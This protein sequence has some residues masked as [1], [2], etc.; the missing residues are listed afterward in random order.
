[1]TYQPKVC[2]V[3][4]D[5]EP[6]VA[7]LGSQTCFTVPQQ[8]ATTYLLK[9][10]DLPLKPGKRYA[11]QVQ[12]TDL[13]GALEFQNTGNSEV[14]WFRYGK[15]CTAPEDL[16]AEEIG[17]NRVNLSWQADPQAIGY[18]VYYKNES[19]AGWQTQTTFGTSISLNGLD[20]K[21]PYSFKISTLCDIDNESPTSPEETWEAEEI[22]TELQKLIDAV[23]HPLDQ[24]SSSTTPTASLKTDNVNTSGQ[25]TSQATTEPLPTNIADLLP[26]DPTKIPCVSQVRGFENCSVTHDGVT[27]MGTEPLQSLDVGDPLTIYDMLAIVTEISIREP[28]SG[29]A[30]V[31]LPMLNDMMMAVE[32][33]NVEIK[34]SKPVAKGGCVT[35]VPSNGYFRA[36]TGLSRE[37]LKAEEVALIDQIRRA[38]DPGS[39]YTT[40]GQQI[41]QYDQTT[42]EIADA[43]ATGQSLSTEQKEALLAQTIS[44]NSQI[45]T[46]LENATDLIGGSTSGDAILA[47]IQAILDQLA[48]NQTA[49]EAGTS[50]PSV[51]NIGSTITGITD[52]IRT[53]LDTPP[54]DTPRIQNLQATKITEKSATLTWEG[55]K[56][57]T[58]YIVSVQKPGEGERIFEV[59]NTK[60]TV[61]NLTK[62]SNY[63]VK[64]IGYEGNQIVDEYQNGYFTTL[65]S[66]L[67][68]PENLKIIHLGEGKANVTWDKNAL[69]LKYKLK[70][71]DKAG[72]IKYAYPTNNELELAGLASDDNFHLELVAFSKTDEI[73][74]PAVTDFESPN[75]CNR[76]KY[77]EVS[78]NNILEG[79]SVTITAPN[80]DSEVSWY[81]NNTLIFIAGQSHTF[82]PSE[83]TNYKARCTIDDPNYTIR[84]ASCEAIT[85]ILV[86]P[87]CDDIVAS[88]TPNN[89]TFG[90][91]ALLKVNG[92]KS[93]I[94]W[95]NDLEKPLFSQNSR[96]INPDQIG[97]TNY[98]VSCKNTENKT[99]WTKL[100]FNVGIHCDLKYSIQSTG[101]KSER[102]ST[103]VLSGC[104]TTPSFDYSGGGKAKLT[105]QG[106][107]NSGHWIKF[108]NINQDLTLNVKCGSIC[109]T[110]INVPGLPW[111][112]SQDCDDFI[113][114]KISDNPLVIGIKNLGPIPL[115][116]SWSDIP[117]N[118]EN[119]NEKYKYLTSREIP[120]PLKE[121]TKYAVTSLGG[122]MAEIVL[123]PTPLTDQSLIEC[124]EFKIIPE[125]NPV[126]PDIVVDDPFL[127]VSDKLGGFGGI[128]GIP[129]WFFDKMVG[130]VLTPNGSLTET[131]YLFTNTLTA[132][133]CNGT[134]SW[135]FE[136]QKIGG[137]FNEINKTLDINETGTY[138]ATCSETGKTTTVNV[139]RDV[140]IKT[141]DNTNQIQAPWNTFPGNNDP[142]NQE[143]NTATP[144]PQG[145][146]CS[147]LSVSTDQFVEYG[148]S[149]E[150]FATCP[151][152]KIY[153]QRL[154]PIIA[155]DANNIIQNGNSIVVNN[156]RNFSQYAATCEINN[157][158][159]CVKR[160]NIFVNC[161]L[162]V[163]L[164]NG[165]V[166][167][168]GCPGAGPLFYYKYYGG[169]WDLT[170]DDPSTLK[171]V[172]CR[173]ANYHLV[174]MVDNL[175]LSTPSG[176][177]NGQT[178]LTA[179][180]TAETTD[181]LQPTAKKAAQVFEKLLCDDLFGVYAQPQADGTKK[182]SPDQAR[183]ILESFKNVEKSEEFNTLGFYLPEL[184]DQMA[185]D[186]ANGNCPAL[187]TALTQNMTGDI[188]LSSTEI[189]DALTKVLE[190]AEGGII[191]GASDLLAG[192]TPPPV[193]MDNSACFDGPNPPD[194][195]AAAIQTWYS[196]DVLQ[197]NW[198]YLYKD[199]GNFITIKENGKYYHIARQV[200]DG[201]G[202]EKFIFV[203]AGK[204]DYQEFKPVGYACPKDVYANYGNQL[205]KFGNLMEFTI[206]QGGIIMCSA[207]MGAAGSAF[208]GA[209]IELM[210]EYANSQ[211][212]ISSVDWVNVGTNLV[213]TVGKF[214]KPAKEVLKLLVDA[215]L[216]Y[217]NKDG[218]Q[219]ILVE[220]DGVKQ[221][222]LIKAT[223]EVIVGKISSTIRSKYEY[224]TFERWVRDPQAKVI[225]ENFVSKLHEFSASFIENYF[226]EKLN[227]K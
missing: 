56:R 98:T 126:L 202:D 108:T 205:N 142:L 88:V 116:Q 34:A 216:D 60:L 199:W 8:T 180:A 178:D 73:S 129:L 37:D 27:L 36:R 42:K 18:K 121:T 15:A 203:E 227:S 223:S 64:I 143:T 190:Q 83:T 198:E 68:K 25:P 140:P 6:N 189:T 225:Y 164:V 139:I 149:A 161:N 160:V 144:M 72:L 2:E 124:P 148:K 155:G 96:I 224:Y 125:K 110:T 193:V 13:N 67:P 113:L 187:V 16:K 213:P 194:A 9:A 32:F 145:G 19:A 179:N 50:F 85:E 107:I 212:D 81:V 153:W 52:Q 118:Y 134:V 200:T 132:V 176:R 128:I 62:S 59:E 103:I 14:A 47:Q 115:I 33:S 70:Y 147:K 197:K 7:I 206:V 211:G 17:P 55:D 3:A 210:K 86:K 158:P 137:Y 46:W 66:N 93:D 24:I 28:Y 112:R 170:K 105:G 35:N 53:L 191:D 152:G 135:T 92:C 45:S 12:A 48:S 29:K 218:W 133:N 69:H 99:C 39:T 209:A 174:C 117:G 169:N 95:Y 177:V 22:D 163:K 123:P 89:P 30:L 4:E 127:T 188:D 84:R 201:W 20:Q 1:V 38:Q 94:V 23:L 71:T 101:Q 82:T 166:T 26:T 41:S 61:E 168:T 157:K 102:S 21:E 208:Y 5:D 51:P 109:Q 65:N 167:V 43:T 100:N 222:S 192:L 141:W 217:T 195:P 220:L 90:N 49:I 159:V 58:K 185:T 215:A 181:C 78:A 57:F 63:N 150:L 136:G 151:S 76:F 114:A 207:G 165:K 214:G 156:I 106:Q 104:P 40:F 74:D 97:E 79:E 172:E 183:V 154:L 119:E 171:K 122:C 131:I 173:D 130:M 226:I 31:K 44:L 146:D 162:N 175:T 54:T 186:F 219:A 204:F 87:K 184:T 77:L 80:C 138:T 91:P 196:S 11:W 120:L 182:L 10:S 111:R 75:I 221:K